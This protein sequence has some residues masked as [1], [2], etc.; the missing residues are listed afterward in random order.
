MITGIS[1]YQ[2]PR[3]TGSN[4]SKLLIYLIM[5]DAVSDQTEGELRNLL[6]I[7]WTWRDNIASFVRIVL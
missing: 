1:I 3:K 7:I 2:L 5:K 6:S 4:L